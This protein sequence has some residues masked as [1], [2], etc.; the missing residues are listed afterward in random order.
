MPTRNSEDGTFVSEYD[1][2]RDEIFE[3]FHQCEKEHGKAT[4]SLFREHYAPR[5]AI[6]REFDSFS[7]A[8]VLSGIENIGAIR[9]K[10]ARSILNEQFRERTRLQEIIT[11]C[12][13]GDASISTSEGRSPYFTIQMVN[14][15]FIRWIRSQFGKFGTDVKVREREIA[16]GFQDGKYAYK[17][18]IYT[19]RSRRLESLSQYR[20]WYSGEDDRK[21]FPVKEIELTPTVL[22]MWYVCDGGISTGDR[23]NTKHYARISCQNE[24]D[25]KDSINSMFDD[26]PF[27]PNWNDGG[28]FTFGLEGSK[29]FWNYVGDPLPGF[30]HK[31]PDKEYLE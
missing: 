3:L 9:D 29:R 21:R 20:D 6:T 26:L 10:N 15:E 12:L 25:R 30:E 7:E 31:W 18:K 8:K 1:L 17:G 2:D 11:G 13:M 22:K 19:F 28:R 27:E 23:W 24:E 16:T 4:L 14:E 5:S